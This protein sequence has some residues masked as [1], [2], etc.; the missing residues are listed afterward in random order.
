MEK[1]INSLSKQKMNTY[2]KINTI[3]K[4]DDNHKIIMG[5]YS[6]EEFR[7]L[8][9]NIWEWSEKIDGTNIR[10]MWNG[11]D[12]IFGGK[13]NNASIPVFL[14]YKLQ[15]FFDGTKKRKMF[16]DKFGTEGNVCLYGEGFGAKIQKGGGNYIKDGVSFIL[17]D[18]LINDYW[19]ERK[20]VEDIAKYFGLSVVPI[21]GEGTFQEMIDKV[22][23]G[24]NSQWG[25]FKAEG[26]VA[27]P[28]V[29]LKDRRG[30][31]IIAKLKYRD[32]IN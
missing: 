32:F 18:V 3:F 2:H 28:I 11:R 5:D 8:A 17:F 24:F 6:C 26:I 10:V 30:D 21:I 4:R 9:N 14:L 15:E 20:N 19:I 31:R 25:D 7:Y 29:E 13:T 16:I 27:K 22:K 23:I 1:K 12:V